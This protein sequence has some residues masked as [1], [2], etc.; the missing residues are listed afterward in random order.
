MIRNSESLHRQTVANQP[1][2]R[3]QYIWET[4]AEKEELESLW[5]T[6]VNR[7]WFLCPKVDSSLLLSQW[8]IMIMISG[9]IPKPTTM[10]HHEVRHQSS[11]YHQ[12]ALNVMYH[13]E[14]LHRIP[15]CGCWEDPLHR[16][17]YGT[18][19]FAVIDASAVRVMILVVLADL[20]SITLTEEPRIELDSEWYDKRENKW[21]CVTL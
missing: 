14:L 5:S 11:R 19:E 8:S 6:P 20:S 7:R 15:H 12:Y 1:D 4:P 3:L 18:S 10:T 21:A 2:Q 13:T 17:R 9:H 16:V